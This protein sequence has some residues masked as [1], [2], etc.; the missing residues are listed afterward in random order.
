MYLDLL[1]K[2]RKY[3]DRRFPEPGSKISKR[4]FKRRAI[5]RYIY[6][7]TMLKLYDNME[8]DP[9]DI[10]YDMLVYR[11]KQLNSIDKGNYPQR[12]LRKIY[13]RV[14]TIMKNFIDKE[15]NL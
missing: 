13:I 5:E 1:E 14:L 8:K 9:S 7:E 11:N 10:L 4:A 15:E 12:S 3:I 6:E 2:L